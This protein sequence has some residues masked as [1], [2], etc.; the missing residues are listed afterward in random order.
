MTAPLALL[1]AE[2]DQSQDGQP[3]LKYYKRGLINWDQ[4]KHLDDMSV[5]DVLNVLLLKVCSGDDPES[6]IGYAVQQLTRARPII[7]ANIERN[8]RPERIPI[9]TEVRTRITKSCEASDWTQAAKDS[10]R[11][12]AT[13]EVSAVH[14]AHGLSYEVR[15]SDGTVGHYEPHELIPDTSKVEAV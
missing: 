13:G 7:E 2:V 10:R 3:L 6:D 14:D 15:H 1:I 5:G 12:N 8:G 11:H 9:G 4:F